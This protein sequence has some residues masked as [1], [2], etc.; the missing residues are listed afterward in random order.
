MVIAYLLL[1]ICIGLSFGIFWVSLVTGV[2]L[3]AESTRGQTVPGLSS[4][5]KLWQSIAIIATATIIVSMSVILDISGFGG[6]IQDLVHLLVIVLVAVCLRRVGVGAASALLTCLAAV[7]VFRLAWLYFIGPYRLNWPYNTWFGVV[8]F[9]SVFDALRAHIEF[10]EDYL[11]SEYLV[12]NTPK[13]IMELTDGKGVNIWFAF[14]N[15]YLPT[16][17]DWGLVLW[18]IRRGPRNG[19]LKA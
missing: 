16:L 18:G 7:V 5:L 9:Q 15:I 17:L 2:R 10:G 12:R 4:R 11:T 1:F 8:M 13:F 6:W 3:L 19:G 14:W